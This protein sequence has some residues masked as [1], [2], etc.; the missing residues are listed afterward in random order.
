[1]RSI[2]PNVVEDVCI[3][4]KIKGIFPQITDWP[5][6]EWKN[7]L[8]DEYITVDN[9]S[10]RYE[11]EYDVYRISFNIILCNKPY[12]RWREIANMIKTC[13]VTT[14]KWKIWVRWRKLIKI[15]PASWSQRELI[16]SKE[17]KCLGFDLFIYM[18]K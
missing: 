9:I 11:C 12:S 13:L 2:E 8:P 4:L 3:Y 14:C 7:P 16:V 5:P 17:R 18:C 1:M 15:V 10:V 6:I